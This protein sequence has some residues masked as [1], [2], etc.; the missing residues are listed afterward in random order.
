MLPHQPSGSHLAM[1]M[2]LSSSTSSALMPALTPRLR[3]PAHASPTVRMQF[4]FFGGGGGKKKTAAK[5]KSPLDFFGGGD[6]KTPAKESKYT[7]F[8]ATDTGNFYDYFDLP[9]K[10]LDSIKLPALPGFVQT[11]AALSRFDESLVLP[12]VSSMMRLL[13]DPVDA[14]AIIHVLR[15][16]RFNDAIRAAAVEESVSLRDALAL[17]G[18]D[19]FG[20][21][22][23]ALEVIIELGRHAARIHHN[24]IAEFLEPE[25]PAPP[26]HSDPLGAAGERPGGRAK[27]ARGSALCAAALRA[28]SRAPTVI[29]KHHADAVRLWKDRGTGEVARCAE[30]ALMLAGEAQDRLR[31]RIE[32][33]GAAL[34]SR[35]REGSDGDDVAAAD[36][37]GMDTDDDDLGEDNDGAQVVIPE[38]VDKDA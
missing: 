1:L 33:G 11:L 14:L 4:D 29:T 2:L 23:G 21:N 17:R 13:L 20:V 38:T 26:L 10:L 30:R 27:P 19:A 12:H 6:G 7:I 35:G 5:S 25:E 8:P 24:A 32:A 18:P 31:A 9:G 37:D 34:E 36:G 16:R 28:L 3:Q 15:A 22:L